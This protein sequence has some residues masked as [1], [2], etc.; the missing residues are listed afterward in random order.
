MIDITWL[1][2]DSFK[3]KTAGKTIYF[4]PVIGNF[5][6]T[7]DLVI[8][9]HS[10]SDHSDLTVISKIRKPS[11]VV[12][13]S[14]QNQEAVKGIGLA[15]GE[16]YSVGEI[17][18]TA[19]DAYNLV[20]MR[21]PGVPFHPKGFGI[22]Y[23][24]ESEGKRIY[25]LGD[26]ELIPEMKEIEAIDL[27]L[28]PISGHYVMDIDEAVKTVQLIRPKQ[29]IPMHYGILDIPGKKPLHIELKVDPLEFAKKLKGIAEV[30][31]LKHGESI[32]V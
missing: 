25:F 27:M 15:A 9:S 14:K 10:H 20:R 19:C 11:T 7:A 21:E 18:V 13:T 23:I 24:V 12:L 8:I 4:D 1:G 31:V 6:E 29:V 5:D 28:V 32:T 16:S 17:T 3:V 2:W 22:G 26:T 30:K